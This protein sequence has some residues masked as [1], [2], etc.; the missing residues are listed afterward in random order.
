MSRLHCHEQQKGIL[1]HA[2]GD[3]LDVLIVLTLHTAFFSF[4]VK[5]PYFDNFPSTIIYVLYM[6]INLKLRFPDGLLELA[7]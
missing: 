1:L 4:L 5:H 3:Q 2:R 7:K 6:Q